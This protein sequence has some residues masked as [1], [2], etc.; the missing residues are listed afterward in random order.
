MHPIMSVTVKLRSDRMGIVYEGREFDGF[1]YIET[2]HANDRLR[3]ARWANSLAPDAMTDEQREMLAGQPPRKVSA[4]RLEGIRQDVILHSSPVQSFWG[5]LDERA[6]DLVLNPDLAIGKRYPLS[7][8]ELARLTGLT[9]RQVQHWSDRRLLPH[10]SDERGHRMFE[11]PAAIVAFALHD[12]KQHE[13]QFYADLGL[14]D[15]PLLAVR[16]AVNI[17]GMRTLD[18]AE[19][20]DPQ[21]LV[22]T[23]Q[24]FRAVAD[25][26]RDLRV[27]PDARKARSG[28]AR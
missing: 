17:V 19:G 8:V 28:S 9:R 11:A 16:D 27:Q 23:E 7:T 25:S 2:M 26:I 1:P 14:G 21:E 10:W 5:S 4:R 6:R 3:V 20:A 24:A 13:R 12:R 18:L 15:R 22:E